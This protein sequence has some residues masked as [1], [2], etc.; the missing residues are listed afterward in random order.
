MPLI[1]TDMAAIIRFSEQLQQEKVIAVD[2][3]ADSLHSYREK[4]CLLQFTTSF[5]TVLVDPLAVPDLSPLKPVMSDPGV[6]KI[7]HAADYDIRCLSRDFAMDVHGLF[8]TMVACQFLG[9][10]KVG[11]ADVLNKY[12]GVELD[13]RYQRADWSVR[14]LTEGMIRYAA[15]DTRHLHRLAGLL[16]EKLTQKGRLLWVV[17]EFSLVEKVRHGEQK[18]PLFLRAKG[19]GSLTRRQL[20]ALEELLQWRDGEA[21]RRDCPPFKVAGNKALIE[22]ARCMPRTMKGMLG[23][24]GF[25]PRLVERY[26]KNILKAIE[27]GLVLP[28]DKLPVYPRTERRVKDPEADRR[29][30]LLKQWRKEM[31]ENLRIDPGIVINNALLEEIARRR[32]LSVSQLEGLPGMK[33][34]Q[35]QVLGERII[36]ALKR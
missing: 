32:P 33:N 25:S 17:E 30:A 26:G 5:G 9:E 22:L 28:V 35:R 20:A 7:F 11:L 24:E 16:E 36:E 15:E 27:A 1:L 21:L 34:W 6:R 23:I 14:P 8:D 3:E 18:G 13:K 19:T 2:L 10:E 12:F 4:V 29:L 31:A